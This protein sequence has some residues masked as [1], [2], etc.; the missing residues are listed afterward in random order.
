MFSTSNIPV[1]YR[2]QQ[3][4]PLN[5]RPRRRRFSVNLWKGFRMR[6]TNI[7]AAISLAALAAGCA[8]NDAYYSHYQE[9]QKAAELQRR[10]DLDLA[11]SVRDQ[12]IHYGYL[13]DAARNVGVAAHSGTVTIAG[14][15]A[16]QKD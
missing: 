13:G 7:I 11:T 12:F 16:T 14:N 15:V 10:A 1:C 3:Q 8:S 4:T 9:A 6:F 5:P 2:G